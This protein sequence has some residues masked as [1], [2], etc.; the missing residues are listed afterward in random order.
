ME[1][2]RKRRGRE[3]EKSGKRR[4]VEGNERGRGVESVLRAPPPL[5]QRLNVERKR[6]WKR[7]A[8][9]NNQGV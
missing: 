5:P 2:E 4:A 1:K 9:C 6:Q 3:W 7:R 8:T